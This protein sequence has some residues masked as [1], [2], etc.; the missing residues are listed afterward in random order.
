LGH[1][2][3]WLSV[4]IHKRRELCVQ[5]A[6]A[7]ICQQGQLCVQVAIASIRQQGQLRIQLSVAHGF[8]LDL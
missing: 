6:F 8:T 5:V 7:T 4:L 3:P 2:L 1:W